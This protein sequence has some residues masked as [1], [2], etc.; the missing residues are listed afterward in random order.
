MIRN[1]HQSIE[2]T[3]RKQHA[4]SV[5]AVLQRRYG[6]PATRRLLIARNQPLRIGSR[7]TPDDSYLVEISRWGS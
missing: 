4:I 1:S 5:I 7:G 6:V 2:S 3:E